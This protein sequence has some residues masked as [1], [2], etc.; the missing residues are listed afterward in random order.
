M[1]SDWLLTRALTVR[2][3]WTKDRFG[4]LELVVAGDTA[5]AFEE[6]T[7]T[8]LSVVAGSVSRQLRFASRL[9]AACAFRPRRRKQVG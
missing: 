7:E 8:E 6:A 4:Y 9:F 5:G 1:L 2:R 3:A